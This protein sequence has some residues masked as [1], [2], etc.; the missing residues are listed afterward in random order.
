[1]NNTT[2]DPSDPWNNK[3]LGIGIIFAMV[4]FGIL[5]TILIVWLL[6]KWFGYGFTVKYNGGLP[7][8][9]N[10]GPAHRQSSVA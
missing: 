5:L 4:T 10:R 6:E 7:V 3:A 9:F 8:G 2:D 1:M